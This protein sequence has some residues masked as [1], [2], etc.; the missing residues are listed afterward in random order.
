MKKVKNN[1]L[2]IIG[3]IFSAKI[4][5]YFVRLIAS[6]IIARNLGPEGRGMISAA[7]IIPEIIASFGHFGRNYENDGFFTWENLDKIDELRKLL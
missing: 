7:M 5:S 2:K 3:Y 4:F 6:I 1:T